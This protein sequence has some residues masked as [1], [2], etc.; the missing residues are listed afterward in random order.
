MTEDRPDSKEVN[1]ARFAGHEWS[2]EE[3]DTAIDFTGSTATR[4]ALATSYD[5][6]RDAFEF[7]NTPT[8]RQL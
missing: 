2:Q 7:G 8:T 6:A 3:I 1:V 4:L 5:C